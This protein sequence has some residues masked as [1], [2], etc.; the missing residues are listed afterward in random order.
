MPLEQGY[1]SPEVH[2][3]QDA[4]DTRQSIQLITEF[5]SPMNNKNEVRGGCLLFKIIDKKER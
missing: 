5:P 2:Q 1:G 4:I 3:L